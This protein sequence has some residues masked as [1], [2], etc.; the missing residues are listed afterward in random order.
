VEAIHKENA[1]VFVQRA[2]DPDREGD[3]NSQIGEVSDDQ[4]VH[5][6][7]LSISDISVITEI[8]AGSF[9]NASAISRVKS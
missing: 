9:E 5:M 6:F 3:A 4:P 7:F 8:Y 2:R 1:P